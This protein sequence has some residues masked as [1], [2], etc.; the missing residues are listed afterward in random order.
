MAAPEIRVT[1][2]VPLRVSPVPN[3]VLDAPLPQLLKAYVQLGAKAWGEPCRDAD[4][5]VADVLMLSI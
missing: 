3:D 2:R 1:L 4:F 5:R